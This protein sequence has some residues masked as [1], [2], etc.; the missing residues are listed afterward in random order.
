MGVCVRP[1]VCLSV[2]TI[3]QERLNRSKSNLVHRYH[4]L[5]AR[6]EKLLVGV[7]CILMKLLKINC[8]H[9]MVSYGDRNDSVN[10]YQETLHQI[11]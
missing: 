4:L 2:Y 9:I 1:S 11:S 10:I 8:F 7:A 5:M 3:S 6:T